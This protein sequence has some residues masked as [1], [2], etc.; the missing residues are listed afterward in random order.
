MIEINKITTG[1]VRDKP[2][3][4]DFSY[5]FLKNKIYG[6]LGESGKGKTT[7]LK[8][9][10]GLIRPISGEIIVNGE[11][12]K[13]A[14]K[15]GIYMMHQNYTSFEWLTC[16]DNLLIAKKVKH[17]HIGFEEN[18]SAVKLLKTVGLGKHVLDYP[19]QLSGGQKQRLA[20]ARTLYVKPEIILMDEPLSALDEKTRREMQ[21]LIIE[22]H[23]QTKNLIIMVT[24]SN[25]EA[26]I[27]CDEIINF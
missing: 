26:K 22:V 7:L 5:K 17:E 18:G 15:N 25:D 12:L 6:I 20:L 2:I 21:R 24:H 10:S 23:N 11:K 27:M 3:T 19:S 16:L 8:T 1:Y 4:K 13:K 9:I 14:G